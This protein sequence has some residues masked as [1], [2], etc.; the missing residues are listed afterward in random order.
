MASSQRNVRPSITPDSQFA[1]AQR[2]YA[3]H[4]FGGGEAAGEAHRLISDLNREYT[5]PTFPARPREYDVSGVEE[6]E[7]Q[8]KEMIT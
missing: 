6:T 5:I 1:I 3:P 2:R 4:T 8:V 7:V